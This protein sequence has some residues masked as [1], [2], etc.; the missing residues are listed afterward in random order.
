MART[1]ASVLLVGVVVLFSLV[2]KLATATN[3]LETRRARRQLRVADPNYDGATLPSGPITAVTDGQVTAGKITYTVDC[4]NGQTIKFRV[5]KALNRVDVDYDGATSPLLTATDFATATGIPDA[6]AYKTFLACAK[7]ESHVHYGAINNYDDQIISWGAVQ[8]S[9]KGHLMPN[10]LCEIKKQ[11][12]AT[13]DKF[14][15][16]NGIDCPDDCLSRGPVYYCMSVPDKRPNMDGKKLYAGCGDPTTFKAK[17]AQC[18]YPNAACTAAKT[19]WNI[20]GALMCAGN[21]KDVASVQASFFGKTYRSGVAAC[22]QATSDYERAVCVRFYN[23][24]AQLLKQ[25][26]ASCKGALIDCLKKAARADILAI[27]VS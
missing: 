5:S 27:D 9:C 24:Q 14:F 23:W 16:V 8:F 22:P 25:T 19:D 1:K 10:V 6:L 15:G 26:V 7:L 13:F 21:H 12:P 20:I 3:V 18:T 4:K 2:L 11:F 17:A